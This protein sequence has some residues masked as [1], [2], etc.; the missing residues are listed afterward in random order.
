MN[1]EFNGYFFINEKN[2][3]QDVRK[4]FLKKFSISKNFILQIHSV[5][6]SY[7][8]ELNNHYFQK[9][10]PTDVLTIPLYKDLAIFFESSIP[11]ID[12]VNTIFLPSDNLIVGMN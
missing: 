11:S 1:F 9:D 10:Y 3:F 12:L 5:S 2:A 4:V 7:S 6:D 8:K